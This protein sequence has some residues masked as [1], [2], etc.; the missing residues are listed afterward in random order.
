MNILILGHKGYLGSF[1]YDNLKHY[2]NFYIFTE[3]DKDIKYD[4]IINCASKT[5]LEYC[6]KYPDISYESNYKVLPKNHIKS[7]KAKIITF[8]SYYV[9]DDINMCNENSKTTDKYFYNK[10]KMASELY[11]IS[12]NGIAFRLGKLFGNIKNDQN[13]LTDYILKNNN[14]TLD[15]VIFNPTSVQQVFDVVLY[16]LLKNNLKGI[17]NLSN[18]G[19]CTHYEYGKELIKITGKK[20]RIEKIKKIDKSF[21]NYG[22]FTMDINKIDAIIK[23]R[24]WKEDLKIYA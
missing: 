21:D 17:Y 23:L 2:K 12:H 8:S 6:E 20:T 10:H 24:D 7:P 4:Y 5:S 18:K 19:T 1:L 9:Y 15:E 22:R 16:E 3:T 13:K 11:A 14:I